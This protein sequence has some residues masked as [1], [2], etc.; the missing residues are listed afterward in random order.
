MSATIRQQIIQ[1]L[2]NRLAAYTWIEID[3][4]VST[5]RVIFDPD[6]DPLPVIT[7]V[8]GVETSERTRYGSDKRTMPVDV[9]ALISIS[10]AKDAFEIGE[11][12]LGELHKACF[13]GGEL[14]VGDDFVSLAYTGGG[15]VDYP[16]EL[17][18]AIIT[19]AVTLS[20][21]FETDSGNPYNE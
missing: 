16:G 8:A 10:D 17:G 1:A 21:I 15:I 2:E 4:E 5:G 12:A 18:P 3:P 19:I 14:P 6:T 9:S 13:H 11:P 7:I 20:V